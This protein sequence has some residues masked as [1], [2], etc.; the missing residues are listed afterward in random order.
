MK[1]LVMFALIIVAL[2]MPAMAQQEKPTFFASEPQ[3]V[4]ALLGGNYVVY[5]AKYL[6][7]RDKNPVD[8]PTKVVAP[9]EARACVDMF[10]VDGRRWVIQEV[11]EML[12]W[13][14]NTDGTRT[15]FARDDCGNDVYKVVYAPV[16]HAPVIVA[17]PAPLAQA[18]AIV[19]GNCSVCPKEKK[20]VTIDVDRRWF[21]E[22]H[23]VVCVGAGLL[24]AGGF[25]ALNNGGDTKE[26]VTTLPPCT[27]L[28]CQNS[29]KTGNLST[30]NFGGGAAFGGGGFGM[31]F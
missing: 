22:R 5:E 17:P 19:N 8:S 26:D 23:P 10:T 20:E 11:G 2:A 1:K 6:G 21:C 24:A 4:A 7:G 18:G 13:S 30:P 28:P 3:C 15:A 14:L 25:V 31:R 27:S 12:R 16:Q 29:R 9:L